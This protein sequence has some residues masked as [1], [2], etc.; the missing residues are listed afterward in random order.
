MLQLASRAKNSLEDRRIKVLMT[1]KL[2]ILVLGLPTP[3]FF[4]I[5]QKNLLS[6]LNHILQFPTK[7]NPNICPHLNRSLYLPRKMLKEKNGT[8]L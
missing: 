3:S 8:G 5:K 6:C 1:M 4:Y 7:T 2:A